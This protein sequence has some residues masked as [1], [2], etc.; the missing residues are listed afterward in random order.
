MGK[1]CFKGKPGQL[2]IKHQY[3]KYGAAWIT[4]YTVFL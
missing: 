2:E 1:M 4:V 3:S